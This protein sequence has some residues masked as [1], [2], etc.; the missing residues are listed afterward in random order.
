MR[1]V[2]EM[3]DMRDLTGGRETGDMAESWDKTG[4]ADLCGVQQYRAR[5]RVADAHCDTATVLS[6]YEL[7]FGSRRSHVDLPRLAAWGGLQFMA[8]FLR[9]TEGDAA[10]R[11][12]RQH[13]RELLFAVAL[14]GRA[15]VLY[16]LTQAGQGTKVQL[17]LALEGADMLA[18]KP[19]RLEELYMMGF[20]SLGVFWNNNNA[21]GCG[22]AAEG[23]ADSGLTASGRRLLHRAAEGG[24]LIDMAHASRRS[25]YQ[26]AE[27][28][29][30]P[31][32]VSHACCDALCPHRRNLT[33]EQLAVIGQSGGLVGIALVPYFLRSEGDCSVD[34][35][36][37]HIIHAVDIAGV[38]AVALG[39]DFDG[40]DELPDGITGC[41]S[42]PRLVRALR[43]AGLAGADV[44]KI[45][46]G[47]LVRF[48]RLAAADWR[49]SEPGIGNGVMKK[50]NEKA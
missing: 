38:E 19:E 49:S 36:V 42:W 7:A 28:G 6:P 37:R 5:L 33:D 30:Q 15:E 23:A 50:R 44:Q 16:D 3:R 25:F 24:W 41:E 9:Q 21:F 12:L 46:G 43:Q 13:W 14:S 47:N 35:V 48:L 2:R 10:W 20:R 29:L 18:D 22:A 4:P 31:I 40:V 26:T 27:L 8:F 17:V 1:D 32:F 45:M 11:T 34:D 39:S